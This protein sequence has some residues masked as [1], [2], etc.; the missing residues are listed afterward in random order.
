[1]D[2]DKKYVQVLYDFEANYASELSIKS[3]D[4]LQVSVVSFSPHSRSLSL[5]IIYE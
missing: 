3:G 5:S 1:M 2:F 4:I